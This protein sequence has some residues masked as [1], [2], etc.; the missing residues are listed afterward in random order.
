MMSSTRKVLESILALTSAA[1]TYA[2]GSA[3]VL[4]LAAGA[5]WYVVPQFYVSCNLTINSQIVRHDEGP[6]QLA[7]A[8]ILWPM[9]VVQVAGEAHDQG[10]SFFQLRQQ[11]ACPTQ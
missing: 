9:D 6:V 8:W 11:R 4:Y 10:V 2:I 1:I 3:T 7:L 5:A